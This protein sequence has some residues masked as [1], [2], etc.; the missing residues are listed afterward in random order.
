[1]RIFTAELS[2][3][4]ALRPSATTRAGRAFAGSSATS[5]VRFDG[6][7]DAAQLPDR[8]RRGSAFFFLP[9]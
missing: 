6:V 1:M 3:I 4:G 7:E 2:G 9:G 5:I 8:A